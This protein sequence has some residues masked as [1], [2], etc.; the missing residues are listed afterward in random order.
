MIPQSFIEDL[1]TRVDVVDVV[2][3][4]VPLKRSGS[5]FSARCPFHN[6]KTPSFTVS[7][8]KQ[9]YH[10]FGC[11]AHGTAISFLMEYQGM[12]FI[13]SVKELAARVGMTVPEVAA[14]KEKP[15]GS[16]EDLFGVVAQAARFYKQCLKDSERAVAYLKGRGLTGEIAARYGL[17][18]ARDDWQALATEFDDYAGSSALITSGLVIEANE[19]RRYDRF[20]D[21][22]MFPIQNQRG[23]IIGFGG[24]VIDT[25]EPK[26][27][28]S[29]ETP[30][31]EKGR[32]L[33]GLVQAR[34]GIRRSG[35]VVVVEGYMDVVA[36]AQSGVDY[37]VATLGTATTPWQ[38]QKLL[39]QADRVVFCFDGDTAGR[40]AAWRALENSLALLVDGRQVGF[41]FL[42][43]GE[44]PDS[45]VRR[46]GKEAFETLLDGAQPLS[47]FMLHEL[48]ARVDMRS[49]E[50]KAKFLQDAKP[51]LIA[52]KAP[53]LS[54]VLRKQVADLGG[55]A[56]AELDSRYGIKSQVRRPGP[57]RKAAERPSVLRH[58]GEMLLV[59]PGLARQVDI[60]RFRAFC[61]VA[62]AEYGK[63]E[64]EFVL[65][66]L[67]IGMENP[68]VQAVVER[69]RGS[70]LEP[71]VGRFQAAGLLAWEGSGF[72]EEALKAD[73]LGAWQSIEQR[74]SKARIDALLEK[75]RT[76]DLSDEDKALYRRLVSNCTDDHV[77][78]G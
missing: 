60:E 8:S 28:N 38:V 59:S 25:G 22:V 65:A 44:D 12:G 58:L 4:Y 72:D 32:E 57:Q 1:L 71:L 40:R 52:V 6:E 66:L 2:E 5:N 3:S 21:R 61:D 37:A 39:K 9:F 75:S 16:D 15:S 51:L 26:Y 41:L 35:V 55:V 67:E 33:Y 68:N 7:Q 13:D 31:F 73:F 29:P 36:L 50:G 70:P 14:P 62:A 24:R 69:F 54:L 23:N 10:C 27:V 56:Q 19:G 45:F 47:E 53:M 76:G 18:Y 49:A 74:L 11:G 34:A 64:I 78:P 20:R 46:H 30:L 48:A 42:P 77:S 43:E 63:A 17:G